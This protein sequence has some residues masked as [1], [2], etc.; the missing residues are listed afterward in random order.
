MK[1]AQTDAKPHTHTHTERETERARVIIDV[2][3]TR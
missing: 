3:H 1:H 2:P